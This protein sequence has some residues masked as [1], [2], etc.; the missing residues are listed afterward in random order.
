MRGPF[1][2]TNFELV[3]VSATDATEQLEVTD[4]EDNSG[5]INVIFKFKARKTS[6]AGR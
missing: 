5:K 6:G 1:P 3:P 2:S 4:L